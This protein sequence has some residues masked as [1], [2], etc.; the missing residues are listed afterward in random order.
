VIAGLAEPTMT[1]GVGAATIGRVIGAGPERGAALV[2]IAVGVAVA[3]LALVQYR[4][5][6]DSI[7]RVGAHPEP[8]ATDAADHSG[9]DIIT[10]ATPTVSA[11]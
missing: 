10:R 4:L 5:I 9:V 11:A 2:A 3:V 6:G 7:D 8:D 1:D